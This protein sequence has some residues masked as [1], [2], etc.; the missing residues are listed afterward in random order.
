MT[1]LNARLCT[2]PSAWDA[3]VNAQSGHPMQLWGWGES[4]AQHGWAAERYLVSAEDSD[5][6][7]VGSGQVLYRRLPFPFRSLAYIPRGSQALPGTST[8][9]V[10]S[11]IER[12]VRKRKPVVLTIEPDWDET[13][14]RTAELVGSGWRPAATQILIPRTLILDLSRSEDELLAAMTKK[15]RQYIRKSAREDLTFRQL[16]AAEIPQALAVYRLTAERARFGIHSD[17]YYQDIFT[18][19][20]EGSPVFGAFQGEELVAFLWLAVSEAT[21]FEL[22]GG[23]ND[24]GSALRANYAL[25]WTAITAMKERGVARY[26]FNGLLNDGV[27]QF[28]FGFAS[29]EDLLAGSWDKPL[30]LLYPVFAQALPTARKVLRKVKA[31][32]KG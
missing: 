18:N 13:D 2:D 27:S 17:T 19:L 3:V 32:L 30:S 23:M 28:K 21:A 15:T 8:A 1:T 16:V 10:L 6:G 26:D 25:K 9:E 24:A 29:H 4:K 22:Y 5:A 20:G 11:A 7:V 12:E 31:A 14:P